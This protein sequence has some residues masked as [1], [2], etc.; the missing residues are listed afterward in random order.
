MAR[1]GEGSEEKQEPTE[2]EGAMYLARTE[3]AMGPVGTEGVTE[4]MYLE[5]EEEE[6]TGGGP[7]FLGH[8]LP[9]LGATT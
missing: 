3:D 9:R 7:F 5:D 4:P 1:E 2:P 6:V 8:F